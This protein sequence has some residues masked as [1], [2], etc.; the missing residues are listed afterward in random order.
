MARTLRDA[1]LGTRAARLRLKPRGKPYYRL[2]EEGCHL[3]YRR[4]KGRAGTWND[5]QYLGG[6]SYDLQ[7]IGTADDYSDADGVSVMSFDQAQVKARERMVRR[8]HAAAGKGITVADVMADYL[9]DLEMRGKP[10]ADARYRINAFILPTLGDVEIESLTKKSLEHWLAT[11]AAAKPRVRTAKGKPQQHRDVRGDEA[12]RRRRASANRIWVPLRAALRRVRK[13]GP[14][15]NVQAF[16]AVNVARTR[17]L[18]IDEARRL[19][20]AAD[21]KFRPLVEAALMTGCRYSELT[22]LTA[23]DFHRDS[24]TIYVRTSK[25]GKPRHVVLTEEGTRFFEQAC[26]GKSGA[27]HVFTNGGGNPW[28]KSQ[29]GHHM[30]SACA[31]AK[32]T[33]PISFH[34]LRH[35]Y[36]SLAV[37]RGLPLPVLAAN[38]GHADTT[39]TE[40]HYAH[41]APSY[42]TEAIRAAAPTYGI[43][44]PS[45]VRRLG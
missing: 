18:S 15:A 3:G 32:I 45:N 19:I 23:T 44:P 43:V 21:P 30:H 35:T 11:L 37:M 10:T 31:R 28:K 14:W 41:L 8:A 26:I 17:F 6:G 25:S 27:D 34:G 1:N 16:A 5:R 12:M 42:I 33:P 7:K 2:I 39:I 40:R 38:L 13:D 9:A 24:G 4:L 36:A 22:R 20:N 29:Q